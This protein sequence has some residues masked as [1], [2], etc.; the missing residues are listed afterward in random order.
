MLCCY[1][2]QL[3]APATSQ[4]DVRVISILSSDSKRGMEEVQRGYTAHN[5]TKFYL[6]AIAKYPEFT[7]GTD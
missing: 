1:F 2:N 4:T 6:F 7:V 3:L 5:D